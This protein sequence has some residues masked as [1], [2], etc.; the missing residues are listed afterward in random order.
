MP[1]LGSC[2]GGGGG[3]DPA[4][5]LVLQTGTTDSSGEWETNSDYIEG[6]ITVRVNDE[7]GDPLSNIGV[8]YY[9][10]KGKAL[11]FVSDANNNYLPGIF[12]GSLQDYLVRS[13]DTYTSRLAQLFAPREA[14]AIA[15][16][17]GIIIVF[18]LAAYS[19]AKLGFNI[20][21]IIGFGSITFNQITTDYISFCQT[22]Q[23]ILE[24]INAAISAGIAAISLAHFGV[25]DILLEIPAEKLAEEVAKGALLSA[26]EKLV[27]ALI[28][29][30][31]P[32]ANDVVFNVKIYYLPS[33][34]EHDAQLKLGL[35][36]SPVACGNYEDSDNDGWNYTFDCDDNDNSIYP[37]APEACDGIDNNCDGQVDEGCE[38]CYKF[39]TNCDGCVDIN[40]L[41]VVMEMWKNGEVTI[42]ELMEAIGIWKECTGG[43]PDYDNDGFPDDIDNC[44]NIYNPDQADSNGDGIGDVCDSTEMLPDLELKD[45]EA[46]YIRAEY[47][48]SYV[49]ATVVNSGN[50]DSPPYSVRCRVKYSCT[51]DFHPYWQIA[52]D[53]GGLKAG[54]ERTFTLSGS[55][56]YNWCSP[57]TVIWIKV[58]YDNEVTES[59][60]TNNTVRDIESQEMPWW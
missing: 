23:E 15:P 47:L 55:Y 4:P 29:E 27:N 2:G 34:D 33:F 25:E 21:K 52:E 57:I 5:E 44:P 46:Y 14:H 26:T 13:A 8:E 48:Y 19:A 17:V 16:A 49:S 24:E 39:D 7:N 22:P 35:N 40:E 9:E 53:Q 10:N 59:D 54:E 20:G 6:T 45:V 1:F 42:E 32:A 41:N 43:S 30:G 18:A 38:P 56:P 58:D 50:A 51:G 60:E 11:I 31:V 3:N 12:E 28:E 37:G 36:I